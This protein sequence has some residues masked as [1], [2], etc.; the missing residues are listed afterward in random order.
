MKTDALFYKLLKAYPR[1]F[2]QEIE[3]MF[4]LEDLKHMR[5]YQEAREEGLLEGQLK[6][7][8]G[9]VIL[10]LSPEQIAQALALP[11]E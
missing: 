4:G 9:L 8:P 10:G 3:A 5:V 2:C 1:I 11:L 7:V 6:A